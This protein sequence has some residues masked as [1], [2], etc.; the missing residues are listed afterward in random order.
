[1]GTTRELLHMSMRFGKLCQISGFLLLVA[2]LFVGFSVYSYTP[3][4]PA[5]NQYVSSGENR[6]QNL[7]G[8]VG[9]A[10]ADIGLQG[11]GSSVVLLLGIGLWA[12]YALM[13]QCLRRMA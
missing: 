10:L 2:M 13:Q 6:V 12:G 11:L 8:A 3:E 7:G 4:D 9:A 5:W 1:M